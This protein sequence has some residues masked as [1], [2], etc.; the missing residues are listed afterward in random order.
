MKP[1]LEY[2]SS[3][4][5]FTSRNYFRQ[6]RQVTLVTQRLA[7][8]A[9]DLFAETNEEYFFDGVVGR[10]EFARRLNSDVRSGAWR[11]SVHAATDRRKR[12]RANAIFHREAQ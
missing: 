5:P 8:C 10:H 4:R 2:P 11:I 1:L 3:D 6:K 7:V 9:F 12:D